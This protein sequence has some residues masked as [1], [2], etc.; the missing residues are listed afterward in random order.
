M[1]FHLA[2]AAMLCSSL[3]LAQDNGPR[4]AAY[5]TLSVPNRGASV[6]F[7]KQVTQRGDRVDQQLAVS[8]S[9]QS[10]TRQ[11]NQ[12]IQKSSSS[13][14]RKQ[15][16]TLLVERVVDG[17]TVAAT[18]RFG[19]CQRTADGQTHEPPI[20]GQTYLCERKDDD[21][22]VVN[23]ADGSLPTP[24]EFALVSESMHALGRSNP[25]AD[26]LDGKTIRTGEALEVP[27]ELGSALL[28]GDGALGRVSKF[29]LVLKSVDP[30]TKVASFDI[31]LQSEG[32]ETTQ[33]RLMV[34]G[35]L[36]VESDTCRTRKLAFSGPLGM[37]TTVGSYSSQKTTF[38]SGNLK[39]EMTAS[40][41]DK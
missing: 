1:R 29:Q 23:R 33:M 13:I 41:R 34:N 7:S 21:T 5:E 14:A 3:T 39:M 4:L 19:E 35:T 20:V 6:T 12:E 18:V 40:Y 16:R 30:A 37:A 11:P 36:Q 17:K 26:Y 38:V 28:S 2:I 24:D 15:Q 8:L 10:T 22:L 27:K 25:L 31:E 9:M 32:A